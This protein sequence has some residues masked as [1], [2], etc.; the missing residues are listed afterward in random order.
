MKVFGKA[1]LGF[2]PFINGMI[3]EG[4][5]HDVPEDTDPIILD[6]LFKPLPAPVADKISD[7]GGK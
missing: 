7:K 3:T 6:A 1:D 4:S 5:E 2:S